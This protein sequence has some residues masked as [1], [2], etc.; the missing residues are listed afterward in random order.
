[1]TPAA[2]RRRDMFLA[3][4][5]ESWREAT[6]F[7]GVPALLVPWGPAT[8]QPVLPRRADVRD[9]WYDR[10]DV[11][12]GSVFY[13]WIITSSLVL[14]VAWTSRPRRRRDDDR[15]RRR[16]S[17]CPGVVGERPRPDIAS[18][19][20]HGRRS[21][22]EEPPGARGRVRSGT[23]VRDARRSEREGVSDL[24]PLEHLVHW[25]AGA[26]EAGHVRQVTPPP[27]GRQLQLPPRYQR[28]PAG[29]PSSAWGT[30]PPGLAP[31]G[32][33][34]WGMP[35]IELYRRAARFGMLPALYLQRPGLVTIGSG[36]PRVMPNAE[37]VFVPA[38]PFPVTG[39]GLLVVSWWVP[40][41]AFAIPPVV[42]FWGHWRRRR[43]RQRRK[44][45]LCE[46]CGYDL[47]ASP[48]RCPECGTPVATAAPP[49]AE[50]PA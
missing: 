7:D 38:R 46:A 32:E 45:N 33:R 9:R 16:A 34:H 12:V 40:M 3:L 2:S 28:Y 5:T 20:D 15:P 42:W 47:R 26:G 39:G 37:T 22:G 24:H 30:L 8:R 41:L 50:V 49:V 6:V 36:P 4:H 17:S 43:R 44:L 27:G 19:V 48:D 29:M 25:R 35:G 18:A 31:V 11:P 21:V 23:T 10:L 14:P 13:G 1:M